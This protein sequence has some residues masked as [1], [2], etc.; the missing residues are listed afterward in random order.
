VP[1]PAADDDKAPSRA[2]QREADIIQAAIHL[3]AEEGFHGV[4]TRRI[5]AR[6]GV[7]E[8]TLFNYFGSKNELIRAILDRIYRELTDNASRILRQHLDSRMRLQLLAEAHIAIMS[9]DNALF[10][11]LIQS[12]MNADLRGYDRLRGSVLHRLNLSYAWVFDLTVREAVARGELRGD[13]NLSAMRDLF[14]GGL[15]YLSRTL[16]LH[17][18]FDRMSEWVENLLDPLWRSMQPQPPPAPDALETACHRVEK[19]A[20]KLERLAGNQATSE[21]RA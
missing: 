15:E 6:A 19:A 1:Q 3:F 13:I 16:F 12:Y 10:M 9:R 18:R 21:P 5:A 2:E 4:S 14:F 11:R 17:D 7:S 20:E 8:G